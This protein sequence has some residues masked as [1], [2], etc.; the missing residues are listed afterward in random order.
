VPTHAPN[1]LF[2]LMCGPIVD[3]LATGL[4]R[5]AN[6]FICLFSFLSLTI[7]GCI[8]NTNFFT[9]PAST[10]AN[11]V[12]LDESEGRSAYFKL[13]RDVM[14]EARAQVEAL[15]SDYADQQ[16]QHPE[17]WTSPLFGSQAVEWRR[18]GGIPLWAPESGPAPNDVVQG[19]LG[20]CYFLCALS[21]LAEDSERVKSSY[22]GRNAD[23]SAH[24]FVFFSRGKWVSVTVDDRLPWTK[25][26]SSEPAACKSIM[27]KNVAWP[28]LFEKAWAKLHGGSYQSVEGGQPYY[29]LHC[30]TGLAV[31]HINIR[32]HS[33]SDLWTMLSDAQGSGDAIM[34][35]GIES[36]PLFN[37]IP[38]SCNDTSSF[39]MKC[40]L[41]IGFRTRFLLFGIRDIGIGSFL[42]LTSPFAAFGIIQLLTQMWHGCTT[43]LYETHAYSVLESKEIPYLGCST[44]RLLKIRNPHGTGEWK[45]RWGDSSICWLI[46]SQAGALL[47]HEAANDG[48]FHMNLDDFIEH[49]STLSICNL[50]TGAAGMCHWSSP[51]K[52]IQNGQNV[53]S[54]R[55]QV[56]SSAQSYVTCF[57]G[58]VNCDPALTHSGWNTHTWA[59]KIF[60]HSNQQ[61]PVQVGGSIETVFNETSH[62]ELSW[63]LPS[64]LAS[65]AVKLTP[66]D[67]YVLNVYSSKPMTVC[68]TTAASGAIPIAV[69]PYS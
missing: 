43:G 48:V 24:A 6:G 4:K 10:T 49:A 44:E 40:C 11:C 42:V 23:G 13:K 45:R 56:P 28:C 31:Q 7:C 66:G 64:G 37:C 47:K 58:V 8:F 55:V 52:I 65:S 18:C 67:T 59:F 5:L 3:R 60:W 16:F 25:G 33:T 57:F 1:G 27:S 36:L 41:S 14:A 69:A 2:R 38:I 15:P 30:L 22:A 19:Q 54:F 39:I 29:A 68:I 61:T 26:S 53:S 20:T 63:Q 9:F 46:N 50:S 21:A 62:S 34:C 35:A 32:E 12:D 51:F 17:S